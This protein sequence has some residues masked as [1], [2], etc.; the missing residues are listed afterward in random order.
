MRRAVVAV[1]LLALLAG[2]AAVGAWL[3]QKRHAPDIRGSRAVEFVPGDVPR[4]RRDLGSA[5]AGRPATISW[6]TYGFDGRRL[7]SAPGVR[8]RPPFRR[9]WTF[10][11]RALLEFPPAAAYG[12]LFLPTFDG[13]FYA[14]DPATGKPV[15]RYGSGR[16]S[17]ASPAVARGLVYETFLNLRSNCDADTN[18]Y[19]KLG[20]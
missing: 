7:R 16:C 17:W 20:T 11:G 10:R 12:L 5:S 1:A 2:G 9:I 3:W 14:L 19:F 6:L 18:D 4:P 15:W 13:R 8:L